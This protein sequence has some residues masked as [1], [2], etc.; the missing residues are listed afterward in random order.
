MSLLLYSLPALGIVLSSLPLVAST[1]PV[2][3][4]LHNLASRYSYF[5]GRCS[6]SCWS[7]MDK[8]YSCRQPCPYS[9]LIH[10][11]GRGS[12]SH[13]VRFSATLYLAPSL[14]LSLPSEQGQAF[15]YLHI[16]FR[17]PETQIGNGIKLPYWEN[18]YNP[19]T[20]TTSRPVVY[21]DE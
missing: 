16:E 20:L 11:V 3:A 19:I 14:A 2:A 4:R 21:L 7:H 17:V 8:G 9:F 1:V 13:K 10:R 18:T 6:R 15:V 12:H 5:R